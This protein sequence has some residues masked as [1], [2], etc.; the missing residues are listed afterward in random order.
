MQVLLSE[1]RASWSVY[2]SAS[3]NGEETAN[4]VEAWPDIAR[5]LGIRPSTAQYKAIAHLWDLLEA[6]YCTYEGPNPWNRAAVARDFG[7]HCTADTASWYLLSLEHD[8][9]AMMH[10]IK[11]F[12]LAM[13]SG[14]ISESI[15][16]FLKHG[17]NEHSNPG[18]G[19]GYR[20]EAVDEVSGHKWLGIHR[21]AGVQAQCMAWLFADFKVSWVVHGGPRS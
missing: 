14:D 7:R 19:G 13:F 18:G 3:P 21:E 6:L 4:F 12:G 20:V 1:R 15:N 9:D 8:V 17:D 11:P 5:C 16:R 10:N 2:G